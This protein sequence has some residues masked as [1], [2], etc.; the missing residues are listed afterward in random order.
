ME[1]EKLGGIIIEAEIL[2]NKKQCEQ[3]KILILLKESDFQSLY[4]QLSTLIIKTN[5][6]IV[7][8]MYKCYG[9][10]FRPHNIEN[11]DVLICLKHNVK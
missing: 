5:E 2:Q 9:F 7:P 10:E 3:D 4:N 1:L 6:I 8:T 11:Q